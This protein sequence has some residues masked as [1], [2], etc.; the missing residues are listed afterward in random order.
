MIY[1]ISSI[2][3]I[4]VRTKPA[5]QSEMSNEIIFGESYTIIDEQSDWLLV[6][7]GW[8]AYQGWISRGSHTP[9]SQKDFNDLFV[10]P[11]VFCTAPFQSAFLSSSADSLYLSAGSR[12]PF[13]NEGSRQFRINDVI[14]TL[15][16]DAT[17]SGI[18]D[19]NIRSSVIETA[20]RLINTPYLWGG[21]SSFGTDCS[22][23][24]QTVLRIHGIN[25]PRDS[26]EQSGQG[27]AVQSPDN[28]RT[29]DLAFFHNEEGKIVHVGFVAPQGLILHASGKVRMDRLDH[30]GIYNAEMGKYSHR[31]SLIKDLISE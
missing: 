13:F 21:K 5:H 1:G 19:K 25:I 23:F 3:K 16:H 15:S 11:E 27:S 8:D 14:Y 17:Y 28:S 22:G 26:P 29:G 2:A 20:G 7:S 9:I 12:L 10:R 31:L 18:I 6:R 4:P 30:K 24:V